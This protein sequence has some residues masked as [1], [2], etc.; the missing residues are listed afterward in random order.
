MTAIVTTLL[1]AGGWGLVA[2]WI[3]PTALNAAI[4]GLLV[5]PAW[6]HAPALHGPATASGPAKAL[7]LLVIA[8]VGGLVLSALQTPLYRV[9]EGYSWP[10]RARQWGTRCQQRRRRA[11]RAR[12]RLAQV[13]WQARVTGGMTAV[14]R[15]RLERRY[16][17]DV[18]RSSTRR[19]QGWEVSVLS[20]AVRRY[21]VDRRQVLPTRLGNA[22]RRFEEYSSDRYTLDLVTMWYAL[23]AVVPDQVRRQVT[24]GRAGVDFF[25]CLIYGHAVVA[26]IA[27]CTLAALPG[28]PV[29]PAIAL[30]ATVVLSF[31]WYRLA[32]TSTDEWAA[33]VRGMVDIGRKPLAEALSLGMPPT[34]GQERLMWDAASRL[35]RQPYDPRDR[36]LD[37]FR[38]GRPMADPARRY[39]QIRPPR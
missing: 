6:R 12:L 8:I 4:F 35:G 31:L 29:G 20:E 21:P 22:I 32:V 23:A 36:T 16:W 30:A 13:V 18:V 17:P 5:L 34:L 28:Y 27:A 2:G 1:S 7:A 38:A 10:G 14:E 15:A 39:P 26:V 3:L 19:I 24:A 25:V 37:R 33:A 9:L 11:L